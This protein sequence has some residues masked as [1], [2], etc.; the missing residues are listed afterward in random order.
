MKEYLAVDFHDGTIESAVW[1]S[2][3]LALRMSTITL[4][5]SCADGIHADVWSCSLVLEFNLRTSQE[6]DVTL[7]TK[8]KDIADIEF[9]IPDPVP[10]DRYGL[11]LFEGLPLVQAS[12]LFDN[13]EVCQID[14]V[15]ARVCK[16]MKNRLERTVL[17]ADYA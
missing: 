5:N 14:A 16:V 13:G 15:S 10:E 11:R 6:M 3:I 9:E 1:D 2:N 17:W 8:S 7:V 12:I 4:F